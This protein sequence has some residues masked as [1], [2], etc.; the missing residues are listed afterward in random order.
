MDE[1]GKEDLENEAAAIAAEQQAAVQGNLA[2]ATDQVA[3]MQKNYNKQLY[4]A[5]AGLRRAGAALLDFRADALEAAGL[6]EEADAMRGKASVLNVRTQ[7][8]L[9]QEM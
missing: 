9:S 6:S 3:K 2:I 1:K 7:N 4:E 8:L 5:E